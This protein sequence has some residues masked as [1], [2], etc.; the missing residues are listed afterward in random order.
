MYF[1]FPLQYPYLAPDKHPHQ[2]MEELSAF[3]KQEL[4]WN[5]HVHSQ[6]A[7]QQQRALLCVV[8]WMWLTSCGLPALQVLSR[9]SYIA[10]V[11]SSQVPSTFRT[12][13]IWHRVWGVRD[14]ASSMKILL[15]H[16]LSALSRQLKPTTH[17]ITLILKGTSE[18]K[19]WKRNTGETGR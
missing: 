17:F 18:V 8:S 2:S 1:R 19:K 12:A 11:S 9:H 7:F 10:P 5:Y 3:C 6:K 4:G 14:G 16:R 13:R 15:P